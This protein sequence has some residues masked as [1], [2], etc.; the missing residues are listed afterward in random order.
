MLVQLAKL[1]DWRLDRLFDRVVKYREKTKSFSIGDVT[2]IYNETR[3]LILDYRSTVSDFVQL[4]NNL[5][6]E[7]A[8]TIWDKEPFSSKIYREATR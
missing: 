8:P 7:G 4:L 6:K 1:F 2:T 3:T 5:G